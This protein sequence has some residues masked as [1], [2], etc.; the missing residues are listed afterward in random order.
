METQKAVPLAENPGDR[1]IKFPL[2]DGKKI[3]KIAYRMSHFFFLLS[4]GRTIV[5]FKSSEHKYDY[6]LSSYLAIPD[7][8]GGSSYF[9]QTPDHLYIVFTEPSFQH[10]GQARE[11]F[12]QYS[13]EHQWIFVQAPPPAHT[14]YNPIAFYS[15]RL[16]GNELPT[17]FE[18]T[19]SDLDLRLNGPFD[20]INIGYGVDNN[21]VNH[22]FALAP[23]GQTIY[24]YRRKSSSMQTVE[25]GGRSKILST[26]ELDR[27]KCLFYTLD[28]LDL[29]TC[30]YIR[31]VQSGE[32]PPIVY[33][34]Q[35]GDDKSPRELFIVT[36]MGNDKQLAPKHL[37]PYAYRDT[38]IGCEGDRLCL[39]SSK[40][41]L[42]RHT[43]II[44]LSPPWLG[45]GNLYG[46][47]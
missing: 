16:N 2:I 25:R 21:T 24:K 30:R 10:D 39:L 4:D 18:L 37:L 34:I 14:R 40:T 5:K 17:E 22:I 38:L 44:C 1:G 45:K 3:C 28:V 33:Y 32:W 20:F 13:D 26:W 41:M 15:S 11:V 29:K 42:E 31:V 27:W 35:P 36:F 19:Q 47:C 6:A 12:Y 7:F 8:S 46:C 43:K 23:D 9:F